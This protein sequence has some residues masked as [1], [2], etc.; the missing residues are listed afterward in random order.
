MLDNGPHGLDHAMHDICVV[1]SGPVGLALAVRLARAG[2]RVLLLE[3]GAVDAAAQTQALAAAEIDPAKHD[4]MGI[5]TSR[6]LG[7][8]SNLWGARALPFDPI[9]FEDRDWVDACWPISYADMAAYLTDAV[10]ATASGAPVYTETL[11]ADPI[12]AAFAKAAPE[13]RAD[14]LERWANEQRAQV[15][16]RDAIK[17]DPLLEVRTGVTVTGLHFTE[18]GRVG[19]L[20]AAD[21]QSGVPVSIPVRELVIAAG[22]LETAR[23]LLTAQREAPARFGGPEGPLGR[24]YQGHVVGEVA[25]I[26]FARPEY[27]QAFDFRVDRHG[28]YVRRRIVASEETQRRHRLLNCAFWPVVPRIGHA[29][30][31]SAILSMIWMVMKMGPVARLVVAEK[32]RQMNLSPDDSSIRAHLWNL[33]R[34]APAAAVFGVGFLAKRFDRKTRMPG[35]F[36]RN[37]GGRYGLSYHSEQLPNPASRV[38]LSGRVD[39]LGMPSLAIDL[40]FLPEDAEAT[41]RQHVMLERWLEDAGIARLRY[42]LPVE[43]RAASILSQARHGT[44]QI[45]I[46]RMAATRGEGVVDGNCTSFDA[47]NLHLATTAVLP[48]SGQANP[49]LTALALGLRLSDRLARI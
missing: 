33:L 36:V 30:H 18:N 25:E 38:T 12:D 19:S 24:Y 7:G 3:S 28:S 41:L 11:G 47:P 1:G 49:T 2:K 13:F 16:H 23:L 15:I 45:G 21:T 5:V 8:T 43:E 10:A 44:H 4:D 32:I 6:Q 42:H 22:G 31:R 27:A 17:S 46:A 34:G 9:D 35:I 20:A 39:R 37:P 48:S 40:R 29:D 14:V 26:H